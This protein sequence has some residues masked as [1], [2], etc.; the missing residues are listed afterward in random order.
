[1][2]YRNVRLE[3]FAYTL[4]DE[5]VTSEQIETW[6]QP[7]Y[8]RLRLPEGRLELMSGIVQRR[9]WPPG[10]LPSE[11][12]VETAEKAIRIAGLNRRDV[13]ALVHGSSCG[14]RIKARA[15]TPPGR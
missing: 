8:S 12:S 6:L 4:P 10:M 1:M 2:L 3:A 7:V 5:I 13:G 9:F 14:R 11:K 15:R